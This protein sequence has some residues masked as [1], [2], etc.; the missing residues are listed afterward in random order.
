MN[1]IRIDV[2]RLVGLLVVT[3]AVPLLIGVL[4]DVFLG[5]APLATIVFGFIAI[6]LATVLVLRSTLS[7]F[8]R[9]IDQVA[10]RP[11]DD[12]ARDEGDSSWVGTGLFEDDPQDSGLYMA[13]RSKP[14]AATPDAASGKAQAAQTQSN[15]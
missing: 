1:P 2:R 10:P 5:T 12:Q 9:V 15:R 3:L 14:D 7:E 13:A 8:D 4:A 6:P 11:R